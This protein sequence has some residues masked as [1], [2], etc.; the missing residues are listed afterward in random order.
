MAVRILYNL[1]L[2]VR[3]R[4]EVP[5]LVFACHAE[6]LGSTPIGV[7]IFD[8]II[9]FSTPGQSNCR[10]RVCTSAYCKL[11]CVRMRMSAMGSITPCCCCVSILIT[12]SPDHSVLVS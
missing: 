7:F 1:A 6:I 4:T 3:V 2:S 10:R 11:A 5:G 8:L 12:S 9:Q